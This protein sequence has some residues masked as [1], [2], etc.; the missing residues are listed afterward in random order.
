M[1]AST[2]SLERGTGLPSG[3]SVSDLTSLPL[4]GTSHSAAAVCW[5]ISRNRVNTSPLLSTPQPD[6]L[7]LP[8]SNRHPASES[9]LPIPMSRSACVQ[10]F[11][12]PPSSLEEDK[13]PGA[14]RGISCGPYPRS[15]FATAP[16]RNCQSRTQARGTSS[17]EGCR[18]RLPLSGPL[19]A[20]SVGARPEGGLRETAMRPT[21]AS[22]S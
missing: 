5:P 13:R 12:L 9:K 15:G 14:S 7:S 2:R 21:R 8:V 22:P 1:H 19:R 20:T 3:I 11:T 17:T 4:V 18:A 6:W 16:L 10:G